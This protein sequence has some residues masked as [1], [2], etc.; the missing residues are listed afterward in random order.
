MKKLFAATLLTSAIFA[1]ECEPMHQQPCAPK[2]NTM[3]TYS[4][5]AFP[6]VDTWNITVGSRLGLATYELHAN[7]YGAS[8]LFTTKDH[9]NA[10]SLGFD[11]T[12]GYGQWFYVQMREYLGYGY[13]SEFTSGENTEFARRPHKSYFFD[14][15][16]T[17]YIPFVISQCNRITLQPAIGFSVNHL[18]IKGSVSATTMGRFNLYKATYYSPL[19]GLAVGYMPTDNFSMRAGMGLLFPNIDRHTNYGGFVIPYN[20]RRMHSRR[21]G[22]RTSLDLRMRISQMCDL[23]GEISSIAMTGY[24]P[25]NTNFLTAYFAKTSALFGAS[26]RF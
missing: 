20:E 24:R 26:W 14:A 21:H 1:D 18:Y 25:K 9:V 12:I 4:T 6:Q 23:T 15:D 8:T 3:E 22:L 5:L 7:A 17:L 10:I 11:Q 2:P 13:V 16:A 19:A